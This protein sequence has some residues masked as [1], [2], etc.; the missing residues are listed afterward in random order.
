MNYNQPS[1]AGRGCR[2]GESKLQNEL[3]E[4]LNRHSMENF[5]NTPDFILAQFLLSCLAAWSNS[6]ME[7]DRWYGVHL[8][9]GNKYFKPVPQ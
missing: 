7:R 3:A 6:A 2:V 4:L 8:E 1:T 5:S 9:S